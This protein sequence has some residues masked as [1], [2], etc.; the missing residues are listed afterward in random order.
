MCRRDTA[1]AV[2]QYEAVRYLL[3]TADMPSESNHAKDL[4]E[5]ADQ[6][7]VFLLDAFGVLNVGETPIPSAKKR[8]SLLRNMSKRTLLLTNGARHPA[9]QVLRKFLN[10]GFHFDLLDIVSSR[11]ALMDALPPLPDGEFWGVMSSENSQVETLGVP[12]RRLEDEK[13]AYEAASGFLLLSASEWSD[14]RQL[15]LR[16]SLAKTP[17]PI[18]VG[19]PDIIAPR[20]D[21]LSLE[22]GYYA[23]ELRRDL[24][25]KVKLFG[26]PFANIYDLAFDRLSNVDPSRVAMV[27]DTL[28]TDVLCGAA[29]GF[30]TVLVT[31]HGL[32]AGCDYAKYIEQ[33]RIVPDFII[34]TI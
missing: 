1:W 3:P 30:K 32:F 28:H 12:W 27:G 23:H 22:P 7:D 25:L 15:L 8:V 26:K 24:K 13:P 10:F 17:R 16:E 29:Y 18:L 6:F 33:T 11:D 20:E 19:N 4:G 14:L 5:I 34:P 21:H 2:Q 31:N 9:E